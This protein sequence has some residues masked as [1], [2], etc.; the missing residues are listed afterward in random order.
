MGKFSIYDGVKAWIVERGGG[1]GA[2]PA[3]GGNGMEQ[4]LVVA[5][6]LLFG[7]ISLEERLFE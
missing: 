4:N 2:V 3:V 1:G 5:H 6:I 7:E